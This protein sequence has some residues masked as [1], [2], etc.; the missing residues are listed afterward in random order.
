MNARGQ[1]GNRF[2]APAI[3]LIGRELSDA[4]IRDA[5]DATN[6]VTA[7]FGESRDTL[8]REWPENL[9][10]TQE[11]MTGIM[12]GALAPRRRPSEILWR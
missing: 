6:R 3:F 8:L 12:K 2:G 5:K 1:Y 4:E 10:L 9:P 7:A 11:Q